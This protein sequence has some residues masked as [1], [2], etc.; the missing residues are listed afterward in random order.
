MYT[1]LLQ[2]LREEPLDLV[3]M[4]DHISECLHRLR[5]DAKILHRDVSVSNIMCDETDGR[6][7]FILTDFDLAVMLNDDGLPTGPTAKHH[8]GTLP[9]MAEQLLDDLAFHPDR[10]QVLHELHHDYESLYWVALWCTMKADYD[11]QEAEFQK[12][13][14][15]FLTQW[16][17]AEGHPRSQASETSD[18]SRDSNDQPETMSTTTISK[19]NLFAIAQTKTGLILQGKIGASASFLRTPMGAT[20]LLQLPY[21][22]RGSRMILEKQ[23]QTRSRRPTSPTTTISGL[24]RKV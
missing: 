7:K 6:V 16:E 22:V 18:A 1:P 21:T 19:L 12:R 5:H 9:F 24:Y 4:V 17:L 10:P 13:I 3:R 11:K 8:T 2:R 20:H 23:E 15:Q 14:D